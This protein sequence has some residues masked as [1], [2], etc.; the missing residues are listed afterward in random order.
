M[1][2]NIAL[3]LNDLSAIVNG[4]PKQVAT[5]DKDDRLLVEVDNRDVVDLLERAVECLAA[6]RVPTDPGAN[7]LSFNL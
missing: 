5:V 7:Q 6:N 3:L 2:K 1:S 4:Y